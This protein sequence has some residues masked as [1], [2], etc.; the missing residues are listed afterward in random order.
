[1]NPSGGL[2]SKGHP[3]GATGVSQHVM[4]AMQLTGTFP[5]VQIENA[6]IGAVHNMGGLA[7]ANHVT[8]LA[9]D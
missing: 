1:M 4:V 9:V 7:V 6:R 8:I 2:K 3:V 5:G